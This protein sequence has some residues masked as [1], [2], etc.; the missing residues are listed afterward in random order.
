MSWQSR[1]DLAEAMVPEACDLAGLVHDGDAEAIRVFLARCGLGDDAPIEAKALVV[2]LAAMVP[3]E[4]SAAD[5][6]AWVGGGPVTVL[7]ELRQC[8]DEPGP[9][10]G[11]LEPEGY[12]VREM[13][14]A[15]AKARALE[16]AG[17]EVPAEVR[18]AALAYRRRGARLRN[19]RAA[20]PEPAATKEDHASAA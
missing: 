18:E 19:P 5:L 13:M 9:D 15:N 14:T 8:E 17:R 2:V 12:T 4:R 16:R 3:V 11:E 10:D 6:L 20:V 7:P 1:A